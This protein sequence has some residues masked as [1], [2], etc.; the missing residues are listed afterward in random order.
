MTVMKDLFIAENPNPVP[1][2]A[3]GGAR[4][5]TVNRAH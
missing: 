4:D 5:R 3:L 2:H 1:L